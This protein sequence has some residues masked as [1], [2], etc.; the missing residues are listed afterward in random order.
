MRAGKWRSAGLAALQATSLAWAANTCAE[1]PTHPPVLPSDPP[2]VVPPLPAAPLTGLPEATTVAW[3]NGK[4][5][6][7]LCGNQ[8]LAQSL[9]HFGDYTGTLVTY[10][11]SGST[12]E[13]LSFAA[14]LLDGL[15]E[16]YDETGHLRSRK[17]YRTGHLVLPGQWPTGVASSTPSANPTATSPETS[18]AS[19][20]VRLPPSEHTQEPLP[21]DSSLRGRVGIGFRTTLGFLGSSGVWAAYLGGLL[22]I[23]PN[24]GR[25]R[26]EFGSGLL[27]A[28]LDVYRRLD[29]PI[30]VG[31]QADLFPQTDT[32]FVVAALST[33]YAHRFAPA[34]V[35]G[36]S[37]ESAWLLGGDVGMGLRL[38][39]SHSSYW[40]V[41]LRLGGMGRVDSAP[42]ILLP[43]PD[44]P[45]APAIGNQFRLLLGLTF[46]SNVGS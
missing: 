41:D 29:V 23:I 13:V 12:A 39:R 3:P 2:S 16:S 37:G 43:Q 21:Y 15:Y 28:G 7:V 44:G 18:T 38:A 19:P 9:C 4:L 25:I 27:Y 1:E 22:Q 34:S 17:L 42:R 20:A 6:Q 30:S 10:H 26:P 11:A 33:V 46:V 40:L 14:G 24:T 5:A 31:L 36:P 45:P 32:L 8:P 35:P